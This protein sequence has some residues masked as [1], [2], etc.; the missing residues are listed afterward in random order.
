MT[1]WIRLTILLVFALTVLLPFYL[2]KGLTRMVANGFA[3]LADGAQM[4]FDH[5][6]KSWFP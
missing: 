5:V 4:A 1:R 6:E 2:A 3:L